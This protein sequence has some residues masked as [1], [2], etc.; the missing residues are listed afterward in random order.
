MQRSVIWRSFVAKWHLV[1]H[2]VGITALS[3][4]KARPELLLDLNRRHGSIETR[5]HSVRDVSFKE[6]RSRLH[7]GLAPQILAAFRNLAITLIHR[8]G[9]SHLT[10]TQRL[11]AS[12]SHE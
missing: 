3:V 7:K 12:C 6:D 10:A 11:F 1:A 5:S 9:F 4:S 8:C 2:P